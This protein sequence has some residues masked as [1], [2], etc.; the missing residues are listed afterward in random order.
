MCVCACVLAWVSACER[1][2]VCI[3]VCVRAC[4]RVCVHACLCR[5]IVCVCLLYVCVCLCVSVCEYITSESIWNMHA[6]TVFKDN[7]RCHSAIPMA[8]VCAKK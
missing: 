7:I 3:C 1:A 4:V 5:Y 8:K 6:Q 2:S